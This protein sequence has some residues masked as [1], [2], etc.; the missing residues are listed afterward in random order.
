MAS[1]EEAKE[2]FNWPPL[3][4]NPDIFTKYMHDIGLSK[5]W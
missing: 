2:V 1:N 3:E 5:D 4:S